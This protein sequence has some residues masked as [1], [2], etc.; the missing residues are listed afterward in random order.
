MSESLEHHRKI[1]MINTPTMLV[2]FNLRLPKWS[3]HQWIIHCG[4]V[5]VCAFVYLKYIIQT[6]I[7]TKWLIDLYGFWWLTDK[8]IYEPNVDVVC[9]CVYVCLFAKKQQRQILISTIITIDGPG[10]ETTNNN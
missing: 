2:N 4:C 9:V 5:C 6:Q 1:L 7:Y 10:H 3:H 8:R